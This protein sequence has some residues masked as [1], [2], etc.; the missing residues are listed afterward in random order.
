MRQQLLQFL[1]VST[2]L[3][4]IFFWSS[5]AFAAQTVVLKY[6]VFRETVSVDELSTFAETGK[7]NPGLEANLALAGQKPQALRE[8]LTKPVKVNPVLLDK[9]LNSR[10]GNVILDQVSQVI[11]TPSGKADR[12]AMRAALVLSA[13]DD[14]KFSLLEI[15]K[16]Y[17]TSEIEVDGDRLEGAYQ[18]LRGLQG[19]LQDLLGF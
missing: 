7:L 9:I 11:H 18:Q 17:P 13:S 4:S 8:T 6:R 15:M 14:G 16:K 1:T 10:V 3:I 12:Q 2:A 19:G 5:F